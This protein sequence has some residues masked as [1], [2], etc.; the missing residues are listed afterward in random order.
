MPSPPLIASTVRLGEV[1]DLS[2]YD[3]NEFH[4][5]VAN[6]MLHEIRP[7]LWLLMFS[8]FNRV[9]SKANGR[10]SIA[11]MVQLPP[12]VSE[13]WS[14]TW[15]ADELERVLR[16]AGFKPIP[17]TH[18]KSVPVYRV[19]TGATSAVRLEPMR[20]TMRAILAAKRRQCLSQVGGCSLEDP[21]SPD[22]LQAALR[23]TSIDVALARL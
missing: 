18:M 23:L 20:R 7:E 17:S 1:T 21:V 15:T 13:P 6:N 19:V 14:I 3:D 2:S 8:E 11:D 10:L 9:L 4:F 22:V 12:D 16:D 5:V